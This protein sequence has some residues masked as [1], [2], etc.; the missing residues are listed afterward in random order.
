MKT[1]L[2]LLAVLSGIAVAGDGKPVQELPLKDGYFAVTLPR[3]FLEGNPK[4]MG[5]AQGGRTIRRL[6][7]RFPV[8]GIC[9][10]CGSSFAS[11]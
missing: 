6:P 11:I 9:E 5:R 3:A 10:I 8:C 2:L 7:K 4:A 1:S